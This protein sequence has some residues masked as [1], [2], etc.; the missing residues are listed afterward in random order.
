M[1]A[2]QDQTS[3]RMAGVRILQ[4]LGKSSNIKRKQL[5]KEI[6]VDYIHEIEGIKPKDFKEAYYQKNKHPI[7][8][9][10]DNHNFH[11]LDTNNEFIWRI[12]NNKKIRH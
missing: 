5:V 9:L 10:F 1:L 11:E 2:N 8:L 12:H 7:V 6:L 4:E 3:I